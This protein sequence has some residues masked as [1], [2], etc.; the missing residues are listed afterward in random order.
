MDTM[1]AVRVVVAAHET[2]RGTALVT[3]VA[4]SFWGGVDPRTGIVI[5]QLHPLCGLDLS[6][7][8]LI[9]PRGRGS[10]S[11]SGVLLEC[12][13]QGT[14]PRAIVTHKVDPIIGLG[15]I[16]ADELYGMRMPVLV[17]A[18]DQCHGIA[19]GDEIEVR[20]DGQI[21]VVHRPVGP[22]AGHDRDGRER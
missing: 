12:I 8:V 1:N 6:G 15:A 14:A 22:S 3:D 2:V 13:H 9:L 10:C 21:R 18:H 19:T 5:D 20:P 16:L 7:R 11:A 4:L 17:V